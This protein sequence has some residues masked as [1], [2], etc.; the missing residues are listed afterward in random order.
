MA[1]YVSANQEC[2]FYISQYHINISS[3]DILYIA[4]MNQLPNQEEVQVGAVVTTS[5]KTQT[6]LMRQ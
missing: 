1:L 4:R 2:V 5:A 3:I 6:F